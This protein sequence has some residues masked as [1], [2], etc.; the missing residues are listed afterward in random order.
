PQ[1][2]PA[3]VASLKQD[4]WSAEE[5]IAL[6]ASLRLHLTFTAHPTETRRRT[7][8]HH[9][10][11]VAADLDRVAAAADGRAR[12]HEVAARRALL[13][14]IALLWG[15]S[16]LHSARPTVEDEARGGLV[17]LPTVLWSVIPRLVEEMERSIE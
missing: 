7:V 4:G 11:E 5:A 16:E 6:F 3:L 10:T 8:R 2:I 17:Y 9:L 12:S 14:R 15:T 13:A 1:S